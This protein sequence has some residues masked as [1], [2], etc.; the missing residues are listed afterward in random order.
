MPPETD[1]TA[2]RAG[3][4][5]PPISAPPDARGAS[6]GVVR[7]GE[8]TILRYADERDGPAFLALLE[9]SRTH[10]APWMPRTARGAQPALATRFQRMLRPTC[11][12]GGRLRLLVCARDDRRLLGV[13]SL[14]GISEWPSLDCHIGYWIGV[15]ETG[16]GLMRDAVSALVDHAFESRRLHRVA[17]NILPA[18]R[19]SIAL[20]EALGF[21]RE[22]LLRGLIEIDGAWRDHECWSVLSTEWRG[23]ALD[24]TSEP[25]ARRRTRS[26]QTASSQR[27]LAQKTPRRAKDARRGE[28]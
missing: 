14:G 7:V 24:R 1:T 23:G 16:K 11:D 20:V 27:I 26:S 5:V 28:S 18:N 8:R 17:A 4:G 25:E 3:R 10:L 6:E 15:G 22:G 19:R 9:R 2:K 12:S 13:V 21:A